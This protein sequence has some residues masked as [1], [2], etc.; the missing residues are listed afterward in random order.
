M[1]HQPNTNPLPQRPTE[2]IY[3]HYTDEDRLVWHTLFERQTAALVGQVSPAFS[4][5]LH[6]VGFSAQHIPHFAE[7]NQ[8]LSALTGWQLVVVPCISP[9]EEF[10]RLLANRRFTATCWLRSLAQ[11]DY[12]EEPDM[13]H[14]VF[15]HAPLLSDTDY[16]DFFQ[17]LGKLALQHL[18]QAEVITC[19]QR[20]YWF[21]IEFGLMYN[22]QQQLS[23]YGAGI[24]SSHGE[25]QHA[26]S[27]A[28]QKHDFDIEK[29]F[30][31]AFRTDILQ[32]DYYVIQS[33]AQ[34]KAALPDI[35]YQINR[36][37]VNG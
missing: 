31:H 15:G 35:E 19:L 37:V 6:R 3:S 22:P 13:F 8:R 5:A 20:L 4:Q 16:T 33:F 9:A 10:F 24:I 25:T 11:L 27:K 23:I 17:A 21:T 18:H 7:L 1:L 34:L 29:I 26:L 32:S 28:S 30:R 36:I 2:Q 12:L 14:D